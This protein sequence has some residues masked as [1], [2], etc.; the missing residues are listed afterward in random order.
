MNE[1][2]IIVTVPLRELESNLILAGADRAHREAPFGTPIAHEGYC[3]F[4]GACG[5]PV[6]TAASVRMQFRTC[7]RSVC[8]E[9][10]RRV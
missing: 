3:W 8:G 6:L 9:A 4:L 10:P 1:Q 7:G 2:D 5:H